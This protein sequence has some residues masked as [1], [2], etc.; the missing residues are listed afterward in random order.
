MPK[1]KDLHIDM[2]ALYTFMKLEK[3]EDRDDILQHLGNYESFEEFSEEYG[4]IIRF[5][6]LGQAGEEVL[7]ICLKRGHICNLN[8]L[9][10]YYSM[11]DRN[12]KTKDRNSKLIKKMLDNEEGYENFVGQLNDL[13]D[14]L[15]EH[16][17]E[18][19]GIQFDEEMTTEEMS[20]QVEE[21]LAVED[22]RIYR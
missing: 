12:A 18:K 4:T 21:V 13:Y 8:E 15:N 16:V 9:V 10:D 19:C 1:Y 17:G 22:L 6:K 3:R 5:L 2:K 14:E 7:R 11:F 20:Q